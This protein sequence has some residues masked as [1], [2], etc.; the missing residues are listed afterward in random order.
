M[1]GRLKLGKTLYLIFVLHNRCFRSV[2]CPW[3]FIS[4]KIFHVK[5][6]L[7]LSHSLPFDLFSVFDIIGYLN[8]YVE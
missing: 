4:S 8:I 5:V 6:S 3:F 1:I 2:V 7:S